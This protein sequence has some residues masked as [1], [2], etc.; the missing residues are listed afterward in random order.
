MADPS[1]EA[2]YK[3][4]IA[5]VDDTI[6]ETREAGHTEN[7]D[8][9]TF[10]ANE[11]SV[12]GC[13]FRDLSDSFTM[14]KRIYMLSL[15]LFLGLFLST[16]CSA[17]HPE[18]ATPWGTDIVLTVIFWQALMLGTRIVLQR[19]AFSDRYYIWPYFAVVWV[20]WWLLYD[21]IRCADSATLVALPRP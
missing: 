12:L 7:N 15:G 21:I 17:S 14:R 13:C 10:V 18:A 8:L 5:R 2:Y 1:D 20:G 6:T 11:H 9:P 19:A 3:A 4:L 16:E